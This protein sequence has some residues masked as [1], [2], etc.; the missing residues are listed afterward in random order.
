MSLL[1]ILPQGSNEH[2]LG[3][4]YGPIDGVYCNLHIVQDH[5]NVVRMLF[6]SVF[7]RFLYDFFFK[8]CSSI[9]GNYNLKLFQ[10]DP[11]RDSG[12]NASEIRRTW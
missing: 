6:P 10:T 5:A 11:T 3:R 2:D 8:S 12:V 4:V 9:I 7:W 1:A